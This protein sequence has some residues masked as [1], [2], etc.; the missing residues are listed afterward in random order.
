LGIFT[1]KD[2]EP[3]F[4]GNSKYFQGEEVG[5]NAV[6]IQKRLIMD[7]QIYA[8]VYKACRA[9]LDAKQE[10]IRNKQGLQNGSGNK[11]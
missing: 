3:S 5:S 1:K 6:E 11:T 8:D 4:D 10:S 7:D 9:A 2:G